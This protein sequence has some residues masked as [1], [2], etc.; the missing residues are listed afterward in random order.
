MLKQSWISLLNLLNLQIKNFKM[1]KL[2]YFIFVLIFVI[3][4][5]DEQEE[6]FKRTSIKLN[7]QNVDTIDDQD[8]YEIGVELLEKFKKT[9]KIFV[10]KDRN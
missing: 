8:N 5:S 10:I 1:N 7:N 6:N 3:S 2:S 9:F 4:C